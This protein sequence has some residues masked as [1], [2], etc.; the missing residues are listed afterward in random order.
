MTFDYVISHQI[1]FEDV[2]QHEP[3]FSTI[4]EAADEFLQTRQPGKAHDMVEQRMFQLQKKWESV[5]RTASEGKGLLEQLEPVAQSYQDMLQNFLSWLVVVEKNMG[6]LK[7]VPCDRYGPQKYEELLKEIRNELDEKEDF[8]KGFEEAARSLLEFKLDDESLVKSQVQDVN[9][10]FSNLQNSVKEK[11]ENLEKMKQLLDNFHHRVFALEELVVQGVVICA[12]KPSMIDADKVSQELALVN[13][14]LDALSDQEE[15]VDLIQAIGMEILDRLGSDSPDSVI[16]RNQV[17]SVFTRFRVTRQHLEK[18]KLQ[19]EKHNRH[20]VPFRANVQEL[21]VWFGII[22]DTVEILDPV[23]TEPSA[24]KKQLAETEQL[25]SQIQDKT[26]LLKVAQGDGEWMMEH[27]KEDED[28]VIDVVTILSECQARM[29]RLAAKVDMRHAR[30]QTAIIETQD[31]E[32]TFGEFMND[33]GRIEEQLAGMRPVSA[34]RDTLTEQERQF[35]VYSF[36]MASLSY[37]E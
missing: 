29:D 8:S 9:M 37:R 3:V 16:I 20:L 33:V 1:V 27:N 36:R 18:R 32:V 31:V 34:V 22:D 2:Q 35:E 10:R 25:Q 6:L 30:L 28:M 7:D 13:E 19:L 11:A 26:Y 15:E 21:Y 5:Y 23:S 24:I 12:Y 14:I 17:D 4:K